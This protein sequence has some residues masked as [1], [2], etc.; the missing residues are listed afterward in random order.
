MIKYVE[1]NLNKNYV[2]DLLET[3][4]IN[5]QVLVAYQDSLR[6]QILDYSR[7][8]IEKFFYNSN[9]K[10]YSSISDF[11]KSLSIIFQNLNWNYENCNQIRKNF[12]KLKSDISA[13][14]D[15][16]FYKCADIFANYNQ[17][18]GF[19]NDTLL[20]NTNEIQS[21]LASCQK[22]NIM[23]EIVS[24]N[25]NTVSSQEVTVKNE[26]LQENVLV[27]SEKLNRVT[28]PFTIEELNNLLIANPNKYNNLEDIVWQEYTIPLKYYKN[29]S[30][31]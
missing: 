27:I 13:I 2:K 24:E 11:F 21:L 30:I 23:N 22:I 20:K 18:L 12:E 6:E 7:N 31:A 17:S 5:I 1:E 25:D 29:S 8:F 3:E 9:K 26:S 14:G 19:Y 4:A 16:E 10:Y 15:N 28:L